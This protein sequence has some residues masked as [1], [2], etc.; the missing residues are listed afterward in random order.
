MIVK[1]FLLFVLAGVPLAHAGE[2]KELRTAEKLL[3]A[4]D[5]AERGFYDQ[6]FDYAMEAMKPGEKHPWESYTSSGSIAPGKPFVRNDTVCRPYRETISRRNA[7]SISSEGLGCKR[8]GRDGW[9]RLKS[10]AMQTC[11]LEAPDNE[12]EKAVRGTK[13][14]IDDAGTT[15]RSLEYH[16]WPF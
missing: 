5:D 12:V 7:Y 13:R 8:V 11:A 2:G 15:A 4:M 9:C 1:A 6:T 10:G 3:A 16:W 14:V